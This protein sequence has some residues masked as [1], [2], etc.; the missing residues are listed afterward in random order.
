MAKQSGFGIGIVGCGMVANFHAQAIAAMRGGH[1]AGVFSRREANARRLAARYGC[2]AHTDYQTFLE[3]PRVEIVSIATPSGAHLEPTE[4]AARAGKHIICEKPLEVTLERVDRMIRVCRANRVV[5]AGIFQ[6]RFLAATREFKKA[7]DAGRLGKISLADAYIKWYRTQE[8]YDSGD[9]RGSWKLD[10]GGALINQSIHTID[11]LYHLAGEVEWVCGFAD[12]RL[13][14]RIETEDNAV[15]ILKFKNGALGVIQG[16]TACYSPTGHP[17]EVHMCGADGSIFMRD[18][19]FTVWQ[20][21]RERASDR[22]IRQKY[23]PHDEPGAGAADPAAIDF[24]PHQRAFEDAARA[25]RNGTPPL[26]DGAEGRKSIEIVLAIYRSA[27][28]GGKPVRLP[29][30]RTPVRKPFR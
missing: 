17:A 22:K 28:T 21:R 14:E 2:A 1:L 9:W 30:K 25:I 13:H 27:L 4:K 16:S 24:V 10:G 20:F 12:R 19:S 3:D 26:V 7:V 6:R 8:Y 15:A 29:L 23:T 5:L 11:L 18:N